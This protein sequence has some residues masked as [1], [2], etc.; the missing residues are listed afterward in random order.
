MSESPA[1]REHEDF[2][3]EQRLGTLLRGGVI[4]SAS[5]TLIGGVM[6]LAS[7]GNVPVSYHTFSGE[8]EGLRTVGGVIEGVAHGDSTSIIQLGVLL[9]IATPIA[10]VLMSVIGFARERDWMYV[11]CSLLV[12]GLLSYGLVHGG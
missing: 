5:V 12:L 9:L 2:A 8:P 3:L 4:L 11:G 7:H 6:F 10:R 1:D